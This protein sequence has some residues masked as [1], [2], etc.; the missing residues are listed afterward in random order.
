MKMHVRSL[1]LLSELRFCGV[2]CRHGLDLALLWLWCRP[3]AAALIQ[4]LAWELP[5]A[6]PSTVKNQTKRKQI[7]ELQIIQMGGPHETSQDLA[8]A[9][10]LPPLSHVHHLTANSF[11]NIP[12]PLPFSWWFYLIIPLT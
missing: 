2:G 5:Y 6:V 8:L 12:D 11:L 10:V 1:A 9:R 4:L 7:L 3:A